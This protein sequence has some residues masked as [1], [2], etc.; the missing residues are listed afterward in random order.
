M[1]RIDIGLFSRSPKR[2]MP[3]NRSPLDRIMQ[4]R[5]LLV[6]VA[7]FVVFAWYI[8]QPS[9]SRTF[10]PSREISLA[11]VPPSLMVGLGGVDPLL[12]QLPATQ[13]DVTRATVAQLSGRAVIVRDIDGSWHRMEPARDQAGIPSDHSETLAGVAKLLCLR[14]GAAQ[15]EM[16]LPE[17]SP[18][19]YRKYCE[20]IPAEVGAR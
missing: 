1:F 5:L 9:S 15:P 13:D 6:G 11:D 17:L 14:D 3:E 10:D 4:D 2:T 12:I 8:I 7:C 16:G 19:E 18:E 20:I